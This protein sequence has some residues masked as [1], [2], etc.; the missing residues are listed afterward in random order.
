MKPWTLKYAPK[1][2]KEI[3]GQDDVIAKLKE[4]ITNFKKSR[5][6]ALIIYGPT[7]CGKTSAAYAVA[8]EI[9]CEILETNASD[10][11]NKEQIESVVGSASKQMSLFYRSK[12]ILIDEIDGLSG[13]GDR[14]GLQALVA[15][16]QNTS[17]PMIMAVTNPWDNKFSSLRTKSELLKFNTLSAQDVFNKLKLIADSEKISYDNN[18]LK[19]LA[20]RSDG[21]L[22]SAIN[23]LQMLS[24]SG[25]L[26]KGSLDELGERNRLST[27][28]SALTIIFKTSDPV[29]ARDALE[30]VEEDLDQSILWIDENLPYEYK[31]PE[32]LALAYDYLSKA[33]V[34]RRRIKRWQHWRF[35]I[36]ISALITAGI[37]VSKKEKNREFVKYK[38]TSRILK[39]W[40]ANMKYQKRKSI[41]I[42]VAHH[43][44][45]SSK[46]AL[47]DTLP[48]L[49]LI[50]KNN[51]GLAERLTEQFELNQ[52]EVEWLKG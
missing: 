25:S 48:Y 26:D 41:A 36:Y 19:S 33:D 24:T 15:L 40:K 49:Q 1:N 13:S 45:S 4:F 9:N 51:S 28:L 8:N 22:R 17:F 3:I 5:K 47:Q 18:T 29:I 38:P 2:A 34:F 32:A 35:L 39:L 10:V 27:M 30:N 52:E 23:D 21:D 43:T 31:E 50:F 7:G 16:V 37:A 20:R 11:R 46:T 14:G 42:K 12:I 44:H 6:K